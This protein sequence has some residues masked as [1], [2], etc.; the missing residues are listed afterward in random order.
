M[1]RKIKAFDH[2][3]KHSMEQGD[4][5]ISLLENELDMN[6]EIKQQKENKGF[7]REAR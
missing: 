1:E 7:A 3:M 4:I 5:K 6:N 2:K